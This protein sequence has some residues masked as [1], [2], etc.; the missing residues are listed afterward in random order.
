MNDAC[1]FD[2]CLKD[3]SFD[4]NR[5]IIISLGNIT[6]A[7]ISICCA[8]IYN[9]KDYVYNKSFENIPNYSVNNEEKCIFGCSKNMTYKYKFEDGEFVLHE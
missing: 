1:D 6:T 5:D 2:V 3:V 8:Y 7:G 4:G 9:G